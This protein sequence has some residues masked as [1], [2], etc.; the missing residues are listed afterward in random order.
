MNGKNRKKWKKIYLLEILSYK[1]KSI[2]INNNYHTSDKYLIITVGIT[3]AIIF[4]HVLI[5]KTI[6]FLNR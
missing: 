2:K 6:H 4:Y 3:L 1:L 5:N